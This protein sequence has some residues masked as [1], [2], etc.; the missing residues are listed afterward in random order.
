MTDVD[1]PAE[2]WNAGCSHVVFIMRLILIGPP[3]S[4]K[5]T[6]AKLLCQKNNLRHISTGDVLREA[7]IQKTPAGQKAQPFVAAGQLV[8][9]DLINEVVA[10]LF[11][12]DDRPKGFVMDGFPRTPAQARAFDEVLREHGLPLTAV[13]HLRV[14]DQEIIKRLAVRWNCPKCKATFRV[15]GKCAVCGTE[16]IQR[17]DDK[18][19]TVRQRLEIYHRNTADLLAHYRKQ[20]L[21]KEVTGE[22]DV[23]SVYAKIARL[24]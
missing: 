4:G 17:A 8:P 7:I 23:D 12:G 19:A 5:G 14:P 20:G 9:D 13:V 24:L 22:G 21:L 15:P 11:R 10:D 3:G 6:Q 16:L 1:K 18:E 2:S